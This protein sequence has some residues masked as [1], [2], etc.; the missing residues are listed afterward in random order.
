MIRFQDVTKTY[1]RGET[2]VHALRGVT[3]AIEE[4]TITFL[5]GP[6]GSGKSTLLHLL[7]ALDDPT[8]GEIFVGDRSIGAF[9][10]RERDHYRRHEVGFIFQN[11]NLLK[12]LDALE[13]VLVPFLPQG[14]STELRQRAKDLLAM[15]GLGDRL[16]HGPNQ[17][18]GGEQQRVAI[19][20]ALL[21]QPRFILADEPTGELDTPTGA[22]IYRYLR[23]LHAKNGT[24]VVVVTHEQNHIRPTD[25][26]LRMRDGQFEESSQATATASSDV[27]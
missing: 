10:G 18:S 1:Y 9:T 4:G 13:N 24:T 17:L 26:V 16:D 19:A 15:V 23:E 11:F 21:K 3:G 5:T 6:S 8:S 22:E 7:G 14:I 2:Q 27:E 20:R 25:R 12:N